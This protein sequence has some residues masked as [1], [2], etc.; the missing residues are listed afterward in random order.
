MVKKQA[1]SFPKEFTWGAA[2]ASYQVEGAAFEDGR[3]LSVW[4]MM[5][6]T[7]GKIANNDT[8]AVGCDHYHRWQEDVGLM[9]NIGLQS[10]RF[11]VSWPR[12]MPAGTGAI[13]AK[14]LAFYDRLVDA[15][16]AADIQP[17]VTLFHWDYPY[18]LYLRGG[19]LSPD[20]PKWFADYTR[21]IVDKL[22][23]R[24][25]H[26][27]THNEPSCVIGLGHQ[28]GDHA[29]GVRLG[30][31]EILRA[32]HHT[33]LAHGQSVQTIRAYAKQKPV[34]GFAL[35]GRV[36]APDT[37]TKADI[38]AARH[39]MYEM[40]N[41]DVW[42]YALWSDPM[43]FGCYPRNAIKAFGADMPRVTAAELKTIAQPVDFYG[44]NIYNCEVVRSGTDGAPESVPR[45]AGIGTTTMEWP[46]TPQALYWGPRFA[47]ERYQKPIVI[48]ENGLSNTDWVALD[49]K[50][51]DPQRIDF[52]TRY[53]REYR[54]AI[55]DGVKS[56][57]YFHW[58]IMDNFEWAFGYKRR[59]GLIHVD[60]A[61]RRRVMKDSA[62]WYKG[63]IAS[64]GASLQ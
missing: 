35:C 49:G 45:P 41:K 14:G 12:V 56:L 61:T 60:Y 29:P 11:S 18:E 23:D 43:L 52:L 59:F 2:S 19:W 3:G 38:A 46:V 1:M 30:F 22:S 5:C 28:N 4:D 37:E 44:M 57:G 7:P 51:H 58:S 32:V 42:N 63:V 54:R 50:V 53:L 40:Y 27:M 16:L 20:S 24:V 17:W 21:V 13:N 55:H 8:G 9:R 34:I 10:Y 31:P 62:L 36:S 39:H 47:W 48:T 64:H 6:R 26:W 33:L 25:K 15:L